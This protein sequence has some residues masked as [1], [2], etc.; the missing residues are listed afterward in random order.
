MELFEFETILSTCE[1][2]GWVLDTTFKKTNHRGD[3]APELMG[4]G[5]FSWIKPVLTTS[6]ETLMKQVGL[7]ALMYLKF[8]KVGIK[9]F[10]SLSLIGL[11]I[12][13]PLNINGTNEAA[14]GLERLTMARIA[15]GEDTLW[16]HAGSVWVFTLI[17]FYLLHNTYDEYVK[18]RHQFLTFKLPAHYSVIVEE[19]PVNMRSPKN[20][21]QYFYAMYAE[22][23]H[24]VHLSYD[25]TNLDALIEERDGIVKNLEHAKGELLITG[26]RP[27]HIPDIAK[28]AKKGAKKAAE[29]AA[30]A[31]KKAA[32]VS[33]KATNALLPPG[34]DTSSAVG[35][36]SMLPPPESPAKS[37]VS[38][39]NGAASPVAEADPQKKKKTDAT[40]ANGSGSPTLSAK[41]AKSEK[42]TVGNVGAGALAFGKGA[43]NLGKNM[44]GN[45]FSLIQKKD[46]IEWFSV[47]LK[48]QDELVQEELDKRHMPTRT[49]FVTFTTLAS[50]AQAS[51]T[52]HHG[53]PTK[54]I[55]TRAPE[56]ADM[57]WKNV[58]MPL[59]QKTVRGR[60]VPI[61]V[62]W[63]AF[64]WAIPVS[65]ISGL[66]NLDAIAR[67]VPW[68]SWLFDLSPAVVG[69]IQGLLPTIIL[70][71]F[72]ALLPAILEKM[73]TYEG[74]VSK[75][76]INKKVI[77]R[78]FVFYVFNVFLVVTI[79]GSVLGVLDTIIENPG[80]IV[81]LLGR[82]LPGVAVFFTN[83]V[84]LQGLSLFPLELLRVGPLIL[85]FWKPGR[86]K[87][88]RELMEGLDPSDARYYI[89]YPKQLVVF[90]ICLTYST[91]SPLILPIAVVYYSLAY[92]VYRHQILYVYMPK[93]ESGGVAWPS[94][95]NRIMFGLFIYQLTLIGLFSLKAAIKQGPFLVPLPF[96][97]YAFTLYCRRKF[98]FSSEY[99]PLDA[100][101]K[102]DA[103]MVENGD[104]DLEFLENAYLQKGLLAPR[105]AH[106]GDDEELRLKP[107]EFKK[108]HP[109]ENNGLLGM[110]M[111]A[112]GAVGGLAT[113]TLG[114]VGTGIGSIFGRK[115]KKDDGDGESKASS[116]KDVEAGESG[117][118]AGAATGDTT[119]NDDTT[120]TTTTTGAGTGDGDG[121][122][123]IQVEGENQL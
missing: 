51:Q 68:L 95:F 39:A 103:E 107:I 31:A 99:L 19:I 37:P 26:K 46:S 119:V 36:D 109:E 11:T 50:A 74:E 121:D 112:V 7:D 106:V 59:S 116:A 85:S 66:A 48:E 64:F 5:F 13:L 117:D 20:L 3:N 122:E 110:G 27:F 28:K 77:E 80:E 65:F 81:D 44:V 104:H 8:V 2:G 63:L 32:E 29:A 79:S 45:T 12:L 75:K 88:Q 10:S 67:A 92:L 62:F 47:E 123:G 93:S 34:A 84:L 61:G 102:H 98:L 35:D 25:L 105:H 97:S 111:G 38:A 17:A 115:K 118:A 18:L 86:A 41:T 87:T 101:T 91:I 76:T 30:E 70:L 60:V 82:S 94:V 16:F 72:M 54:L 96:V 73:T 69:V 49:G 55:V 52:L 42:S 15:Q 120:T 58:N 43:A 56:L 23:V 4:G 9:L 22:K 24:S 14:Q 21:L 89:L 1:T 90:V 71:A 113:G 100:A 40:T 114:A 83:Y 6:D 53:D 33:S 108:P 57:V 78:L